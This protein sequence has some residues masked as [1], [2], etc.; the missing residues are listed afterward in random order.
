MTQHDAARRIGWSQKS[1][2]RFESG[3]LRLTL[4]AAHIMACTVGVR[5]W[6]IIKDFDPNEKN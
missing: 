2:S 4:E 6:A 1:W 3:F 5:L